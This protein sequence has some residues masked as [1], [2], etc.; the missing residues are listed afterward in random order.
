MGIIG[1]QRT[2]KKTV[3]EALTKNIAETF[4]SGESRIGT[5]SVPDKRVDILSGMYNPKKTI[6]PSGSK[7][8]STIMHTTMELQSMV[9]E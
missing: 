6:L 5:I 2:G 4:R 1:F 8:I 7:P 9:L 3:F